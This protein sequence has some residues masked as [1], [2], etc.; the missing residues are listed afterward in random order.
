M[1][2]DLLVKYEEITG[3]ICEIEKS[4]QESTKDET[5]VS[6]KS[7]IKPKMTDIYGENVLMS[8][9]YTFWEMSILNALIKTI[10]KAIITLYELFSMPR[11]ENNI[12]V[13][14]TIKSKFVSSKEISSPIKPGAQSRTT[15]NK[16]NHLD[17]DFYFYLTDS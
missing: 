4:S 2:G 8:S 10:L 16:D 7:S 6:N 14:F 1:L 11:Q 12:N 3:I 17:L 5:L 13:L 9:Y 15:L